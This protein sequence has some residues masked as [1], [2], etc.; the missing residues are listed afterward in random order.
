MCSPKPLIDSKKLLQQFNEAYE[1][2]ESLLM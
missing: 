1:G 2:N